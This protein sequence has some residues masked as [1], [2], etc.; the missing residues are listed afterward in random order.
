MQA[1]IVLIL[2][3]VLVWTIAGLRVIASLLNSGANL[4]TLLNLA[5]WIGFGLAFFIHV[6]ADRGRRGVAALAAQTLCGLVLAVTAGA[7]GMEMALLV[8]VAGQLPTQ[9]SGRASLFWIAAQTGALAILLNKG[10]GL[11][12]MSLVIFLVTYLAFELFAMGTAQLA[13]SERTTR[14]AL[15]AANARLEAMQGAAVDTAR[16]AERLRIARDLHDSLGHRLTALGLTLEAARH[17]PGEAVSAKIVEARG[18]ASALL[19][20]LRDAVG[21]IRDDESRELRSLLEDLARSLESPRVTVQVDDAIRITGPE[22][23]TAL[24]RIAQEIVTNAARHAKAERLALS[25]RSDGDHVRLEGVDDGASASADI[26]AG[27]GL[28]GIR[29]RA[30]LLGGDARW[31]REAAGGFRVVVTIPRA[32]LV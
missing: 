32:H 1:T 16:H 19:D 18:L 12:G 31:S 24:F 29:E 17:V 23:T 22:A 8:M 4:I 26:V 13:E 7:G 2:A 30:R 14:E 27:N 20:D 10:R 3:G 21:E 28:C 25:L 9:M 6:Q 15:T 5:A 11:T